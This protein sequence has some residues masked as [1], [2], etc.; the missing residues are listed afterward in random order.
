MLTLGSES[1]LFWTVTSG[2]DETGA[3]SNISIFLY[4]AWCRSSSSRTAS[5]FASLECSP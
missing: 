4:N 5:L 1:L 2:L 3:A